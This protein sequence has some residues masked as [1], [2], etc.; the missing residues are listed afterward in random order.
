MSGTSG[1]AVTRCAI[2]ARV[3]TSDQHADNQLAV[4]R[5][6]AADAG[7]QVAAEFVTEDS[8]WQGA[9]AGNGKGAEFEQR[10]LAMLA[11]VRAGSY[12]VILIW[13]IDRLS[14]LG[15]EDMQRYLRRLAEAG[16]DVR[17]NQ[18]TWLNTA[19]P[20]T[21]EL[22]VGMFATLAKFESQRRSERIKLGLAAKKAKGEQVGGRVKGAKDKKP[23]AT[24]GYRQRWARERAEADD[25]AR[26]A[27]A[28]A[29]PQD[30]QEETS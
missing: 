12:T 6:W 10:R 11:G 15:S 9:K 5:Q 19:D 8:A 2:W 18:E 21:R 29:A 28:I 25:A 4:L 22:L 26:S 3:S 16:A 14:R 1:Q 23:R 30:D 17:S 20:L 27:D 7:L 24:D 13:A